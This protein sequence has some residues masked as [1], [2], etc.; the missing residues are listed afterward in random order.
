MNFS[1]LT[2]ILSN[3]SCSHLHEISIVTRYMWRG[4]KNMVLHSMSYF[5]NGSLPNQVKEIVSTFHNA[6]C[7]HDVAYDCEPCSF[8]RPV[9]LQME[10]WIGLQIQMWNIYTNA[11]QWEYRC[12]YKLIVL[13]F[14]M[15]AAM[16][17][18]SQAQGVKLE[19]SWYLSACLWRKSPQKHCW[20]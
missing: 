6:Q 14:R 18:S 3:L 13:S 1:Y 5:L 12:E 2:M 19:E 16:A 11:P 10:I 7:L 20:N 4:L 17:P 8:C 9:S 15:T